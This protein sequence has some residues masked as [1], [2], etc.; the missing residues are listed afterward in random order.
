MKKPGEQQNKNKKQHQQKR[1]DC[2][3]FKYTRRR[4]W[5]YMKGEHMTVILT[6]GEYLKPDNNV[7]VMHTSSDVDAKKPEIFKKYTGLNGIVRS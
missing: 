1:P 5:D 3:F 2:E 6:A 7:A 4:R